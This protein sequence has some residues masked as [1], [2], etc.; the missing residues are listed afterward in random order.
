MRTRKCSRE[1]SNSNKTVGTWAKY[2]TAIEWR[3]KKETQTRL[4]KRESR[5]RSKD[6]RV[7]IFEAAGKKGNRR[8]RQRRRR[9]AATCKQPN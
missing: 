7:T 8:R 1:P 3:R 9:Q 4:A 6:K 2:K 5:V